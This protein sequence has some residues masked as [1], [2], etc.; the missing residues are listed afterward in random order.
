MSNE[1]VAQL[2]AQ[3]IE[4]FHSADHPGSAIDSHLEVDSADPNDVEGFRS[5]FL[6]KTRESCDQLDLQTHWDLISSLTDRGFMYWAPAFMLQALRPDNGAGLI[7][8]SIRRRADSIAQ[9]DLMTRQQRE[10][11]EHFLRFTD[12]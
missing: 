4:A 1:R 12:A 2:R 6:E 11:I 10:T 3:I 7:A 8:P 5:C 9:R